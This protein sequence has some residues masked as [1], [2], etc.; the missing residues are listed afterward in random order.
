MLAVTDNHGSMIA[1]VERDGV[2]RARLHHMFLDAPASVQDALIRYVAYAD[3]T[4]STTVGNYI[5]ANNHRIRASRPCLRPL[6]TQGEHHD[7][8]GILSRLNKSYFG[9]TIDALV[10]WGKWS[11]HAPSKARRSLKLG[12]YSAV[13]RLIRIHPV[14]DRAWVPR[15]F[16]SY[17]AYHEMLHHVIPAV[18]SGRRRVLHPP[19]FISRERLF[20]DYERA[21]AWE[22]AHLHRLLRARS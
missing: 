18:K 16:V 22:R 21:M 11:A 1:F 13:E 20:R 6:Q 3:R 2:L 9:G 19:A 5:E 14:L 17:V 7:L 12:S 15:Y 8:L 10:T 4:A